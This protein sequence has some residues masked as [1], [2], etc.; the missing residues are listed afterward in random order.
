[1]PSMATALLE[2]TIMESFSSAYAR[3]LFPRR[4][5][6]GTGRQPVTLAPGALEISL[7]AAIYRLVVAGERLLESTRRLAS[8]W[9]AP[10]ASRPNT[11]PVGCG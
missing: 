3:A 11:T 5:R 4:Y 10:A 7:S 9:K 8:R 6:P 2:D 1:M